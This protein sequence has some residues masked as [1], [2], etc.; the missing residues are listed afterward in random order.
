MM[1]ARRERQF[2][3]RHVGGGRGLFC[4]AF[5][6]TNAPGAHVYSHELF[7][8]LPRAQAARALAVSEG[9]RAR[10]DA[11]GARVTAADEAARTRADAA[12]AAAEQAQQAQQQQFDRA[13]A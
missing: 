3:A 11:L 1:R 10:V 9:E 6:G 12:V 2:K 7:V 4:H 5:S 8:S 13:V